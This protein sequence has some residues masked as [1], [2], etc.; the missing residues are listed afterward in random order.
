[1][2]LR[3]DFFVDGDEDRDDSERDRVVIPL[4]K[5][6]NEI[7]FPPQKDKR[8]SAPQ[9]WVSFGPAGFRHYCARPQ[10]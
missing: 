1:M 3:V 10:A 6:K 8:N 9:G 4:G 5:W 7:F 2:K